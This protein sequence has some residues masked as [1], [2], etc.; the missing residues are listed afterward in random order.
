MTLRLP[1]K[2]RPGVRLIYVS[3]ESRPGVDYAVQHIRRAGQNRWFCSCPQFVYRCL[4]RRR[5]CK[6]VRFA[7]R[8]RGQK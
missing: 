1:K 5:H 6:H 7:R 2:Q 8:Q 4:A 3:S